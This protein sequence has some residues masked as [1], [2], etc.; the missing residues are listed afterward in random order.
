MRKAQVKTTSLALRSLEHVMAR[1]E[2]LD[3]LTESG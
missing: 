2:A 3:L 1:D